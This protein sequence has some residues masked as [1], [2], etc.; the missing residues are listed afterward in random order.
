M[1]KDLLF[2]LYFF[3]PVGLANMVPPI[4][5]KVAFLKDLNFPIDFNYQLRGKPIFGSHKT[6]RG[7]IGGVIVAIL[8]LWLEVYIF[9]HS[10]FIQSITPKDINYRTLPV[11]LL[12][13]LFGVGALMG[14]AVESFFKRQIGIESGKS[15]FFF[16]Q[17]DYIFGAILTTFWIVSLDLRR[18]ILL[19][20]SFFMLHVVFSL[21]GYLIKVKN[22]PF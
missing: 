16:D 7:L 21:I 18:Y 19:V 22:S 3:A 4:L 13:F 17:T 10:H 14:D 6:W 1:I 5:S 2:V 9:D 15:L 8:V 20:I 12:G 11:L